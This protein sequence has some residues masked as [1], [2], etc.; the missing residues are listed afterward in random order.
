MED[1]STRFH[2][3]FSSKLDCRKK[4]IACEHCGRVLID[5]EIK[6]KAEDKVG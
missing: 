2:H 3:K 4:I 1:V 6:A 5:D